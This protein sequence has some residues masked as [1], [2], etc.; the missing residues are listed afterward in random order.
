MKTVFAVIALVTFALCSD[1][2]SFDPSI[3]Q[4]IEYEHRSLDL[5][6][7][8]NYNGKHFHI[9]TDDEWNSGY[10]RSGFNVTLDYSKTH[11]T[12]LIVD[13]SSAGL[14][15]RSENDI[16]YRNEEKRKNS[17]GEL[18]VL[19]EL[20][21]N[22]RFSRYRYRTPEGF[23]TS[24]IGGASWENQFEKW[25]VWDDEEDVGNADGIDYGTDY[26]T[27]QETGFYHLS[28]NPQLGFYLGKGRVH[29]VGY[30]AVACHMVQKLQESGKAELVTAE[31]VIAI[32]E[33]YEA[34]KRE[35]VWD[36]R[37]WQIKQ[38]TTLG[39]W[40]VA[41]NIVSDL[42]VKDVME[43]LDLWE[44]G[45]N[46]DRSHGVRFK[47]G[48]NVN[49]KLHHNASRVGESDSHKY[50]KGRYSVT[51]ALEIVMRK[52][53]TMTR[54]FG[55]YGGANA[56]YQWDQ[57]EDSLSAQKISTSLRGGVFYNWYPS[58]RTTYRLNF[59]CSH[60][61]NIDVT[62]DISKDTFDDRR[63][64]LAVEMGVSWYRYFTARFL[65]SA[66]MGY[67]MDYLGRSEGDKYSYYDEYSE[68]VTHSFFG[69][70]SLLFNIF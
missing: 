38:L 6:P 45:L 18:S 26:E 3:Y 60:S 67:R 17:T 1:T 64:D 5:T 56:T 69:S 27:K 12:K 54:M 29:N 59:T 63:K 51:P 7:A 9:R 70:Y 49:S 44:N 40:L 33:K 36:D 22:Y 25:S 66:N 46:Q 2:I 39:E 53:R 24:F 41:E 23:F 52:S 62:D 43:L 11:D 47:A 31:Q 32:A 10:Q 8:F 4:P 34:L 30:A 50:F 61:W 16:K 15:F 35:R 14:S 13:E 28:L 58:L 37:E 20:G 68:G 42:S 65:M 19:K 55:V 48:A 57:E 21:T